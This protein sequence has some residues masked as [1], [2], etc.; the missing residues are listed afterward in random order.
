MTTALAPLAPT[1]TYTDEQIELI[2]S[3]VAR[4]CTRDELALFLYQCK[5]TG[6]DAMSRQ[7]YCIKRGGRMTIQTSID[8]FRL[9]AQRTGQYRGQT[10]PLWCGED[11]AWKD[12][13]L[14]SKPPSAAKVGVYRDGFS[15]PCYAVARFDGYAQ[16]FNGKLAGLW[17]KMPDVMIAKCAEALALRKGFP[18]ELSGLYTGDEMQQADAPPS[19]VHVERDQMAESMPTLPPAGFDDWAVDIAVVAED[20]TEALKA[21]WKKSKKE[22]REAMTPVKIDLLRSL[23]K[24]AD[25]AKAET[26]A[27]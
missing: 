6:L 24:Q 5:R 15:E 7:I 9:I 3:Q 17:A 20:G 14:G 23:A 2:K 8:G 11:G 10:A 19:P 1:V 22:Y 12:V 13:W 25:K 16:E 27:Q 26:E 4:D 21:A 18:Q